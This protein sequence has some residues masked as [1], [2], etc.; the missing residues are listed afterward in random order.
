[1]MKNTRAKNLATR[2][3]L[4]PTNS[5]EKEISTP[6][7]NPKPRTVFKVSKVPPPSPR[8]HISADLTSLMEE[9]TTVILNLQLRILLESLVLRLVMIWTT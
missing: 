6:T 9:K 1:M 7:P 3:V 5:S 8:T 4:D 2:R